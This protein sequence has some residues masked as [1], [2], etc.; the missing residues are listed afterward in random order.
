MAR[1][2][3]SV[4]RLCRREGIQLFLKGDRC[5]S[6]KCAVK[7]R[8]Y[9]PGQHGQRRPK[10]SEYGTQ[11]REKQKAKRIYGLLERQFK[12]CFEEADR[13]K[14]VTGENL[15]RLLELRLDN[16]A[17]RLGFATSLKQA[18]QL[19]MH[20]HFNLNQRK[21]NIPSCI[22]KKGDTI[23]VREE[24]KSLGA[25]QSSLDRVDRRGIPRW[26][27][28]DKG[29]MKGVVLDYPQREDLGDL[30]SEKLIVELYSR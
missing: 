10:F 23:A 1:Y 6:D 27:S 28:L 3:G 9:A 20:G 18:R 7:K 24:S 4:C 15:L 21:V 14:G 30:I 5:L 22:V 12:N 2:I 8:S 29:A 17:C 19:V 26:L 16:V 25:I 11:L 13:Q